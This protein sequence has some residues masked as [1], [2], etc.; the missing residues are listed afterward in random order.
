M[1]GSGVPGRVQASARYSVRVRSWASHRSGARWSDRYARR[2]T[3]VHRSGSGETEVSQNRVSMDRTVPQASSPPGA[4]WTAGRCG[5][6]RA[7]ASMRA[8]RWVSRSQSP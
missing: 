1:A 3:T 7:R 4:G 5:S 8:S 6:G 2:M